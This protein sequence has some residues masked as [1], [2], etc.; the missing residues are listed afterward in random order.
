MS[1]SEDG[2][3]RRYM[4]SRIQYNVLCIVWVYVVDNH[5]DEV[6]CTMKSSEQSIKS[7]ASR[8]HVFYRQHVF[9]IHTIYLCVVTFRLCF[10]L[11]CSLILHGG[12]RTP[13]NVRRTTYA[14]RSIDY[15]Y[16]RCAVYAVHL[17]CVVHSVQ[18][19]DTVRHVV[20]DGF[21]CPCILYEYC[22]KYTV[23]RTL[24]VGIR[25]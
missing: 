18:C 9:S 6:E 13:D 25:I 1:C 11:I 22:T 3:H 5:I 19:T 24:Y 16:V 17:V 15:R 10:H 20:Y 4:L 2:W 7:P 23:R 14:G 21:R 8:Q 12:R